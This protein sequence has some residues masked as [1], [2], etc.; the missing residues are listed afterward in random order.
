MKIDYLPE[1]RK[2]SGQKYCLISVVGPK[3]NQKCDVYAAKV[4]G[5]ASSKDEADKMVK[6]IMNFDNK[7]DIYVT[8]VGKFFPIDVDPNQ[9]KDVKHTDE[10]LNEL[11]QKYT[12]NRLDAN[13]QFSIRKQEMVDQAI[14][15]GKNQEEVA[16]RPEHPIAVYSR[17]NDSEKHIQEL[18]AQI[19]SLELDQNLATEKWNS[20]FTQEERDNALKVLD[21]KIDQETQELEKEHGTEAT[22]D[23]KTE[24]KII[25]EITSEF[26]K[27]NTL[28]FEDIQKS[29]KNAIMENIISELQSIDSQLEDINKS[30]E[31]NL[32]ENTKTLLNTQK[33]TL[34]TKR[35]HLTSK[36]ESHNVIGYINESFGT[37]SNDMVMNSS[38]NCIPKPH[39]T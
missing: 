16:N 5:V 32:G 9:A 21:H 15:E 31:M 22:V 7:F 17:M 3:Y 20:S 14:Q 26:E 34:E 27:E 37:T 36:L 1:D 6:S 29:L 10:R 25:G 30:L 28:G 39:D 12:E 23:Y 33:D 11:V 8:E 19:K 35:K 2:I 18:Q 24:T 4:R 13:N 38:N